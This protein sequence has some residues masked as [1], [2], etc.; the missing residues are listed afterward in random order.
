MIALREVVSRE[1][2]KNLEIPQEFGEKFE[3]ILIPIDYEDKN[4]YEFWSNEELKQISKIDLSTPIK[5]DEDYS[6]W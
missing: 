5:D 2:F 4:D 1:D 6:K 3:V